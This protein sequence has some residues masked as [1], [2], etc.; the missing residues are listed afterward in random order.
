MPDADTMD[1]IA[2]SLQ[3]AA[4]E[5]DDASRSR[6]LSDAP[7]LGDE[8]VQVFEESKTSIMPM[9][10]DKLEVMSA[11]LHEKLEEMSREQN[12][13][14]RAPSFR[15]PTIEASF[16]ATTFE[17]QR[18]TYRNAALLLALGLAVLVPVDVAAFDGDAGSEEHHPQKLKLA[19]ASRCAAVVVL[20]LYSAYT[21]VGRRNP[22]LVLSVLVAWS[23]TAC[24]TLNLDSHSQAKDLQQE[25]NFS[26]VA[27]CGVYIIFMPGMPFTLAAVCGWGFFAVRLVMHAVLSRLDAADEGRGRW[28]GEALDVLF[29]NLCKIVLFSLFGMLGS[30]ASTA[31]RPSRWSCP[32]L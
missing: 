21:A 18:K 10:A 2:G 20:L 26:I 12:R 6:K 9:A 3:R 29:K 23:V 30:Y 7:I 32:S 15:E 13:R 11:M 28:G 4:M 16:R 31:P 14:C 19:V 27:L 1:G 8:L 17:G 24:Y 25:D 22:T 5:G